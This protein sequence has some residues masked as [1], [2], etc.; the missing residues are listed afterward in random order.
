MNEKVLTESEIMKALELRALPS[1]IN[2]I[3]GLYEE[4]CGIYCTKKRTNAENCHDC[5]E[6][7]LDYY[8]LLKMLMK[9]GE[10]K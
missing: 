2:C 9:E 6:H 5:K 7:S 3:H 4:A 10:E 1:E 8:A